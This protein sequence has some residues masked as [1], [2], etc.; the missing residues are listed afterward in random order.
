MK[1]EGIVGEDAVLE[2]VTGRS[3]KE[4]LDKAEWQDGEI[5]A[6]GTRPR[7]DIRRVFLGSRSGE[8]I[9]DSPVPVL[10]LPG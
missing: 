3:W 8:I 10:V 7:G 1:T 9:R 4:A 2:V 6:L 5:L